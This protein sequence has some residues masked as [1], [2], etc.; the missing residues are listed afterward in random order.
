[1][2]TAHQL[3]TNNAASTLNGTLSVGATFFNVA[4]GHGTR[5]PTPGAGEYFHV[6][7][8]EI[9]SSG[10]EI[11]YEI[12]RC[13]AISGDTL[14]VQ[15]DVEGVV[16]AAGGTSGGWA[17]PSA[18]GINPSQ[19][20][21][22]ELRHTA[23]AAGNALAKDGNLAGLDSVATARTN[24][25][26]GSLATQAANAVAISGGTIAG[27]T[28]DNATIN[29]VD[30]LSTFADN[31]DATKKARFELGGITAG[32]TR[33]LTVPDTNGTLATT[34]AAQ[35]LTNKTLALGSNTVSGTKA[36][37]DAALTDDNFAFVGQA[38][39]FTQGQIVNL[40]ASTAEA[41]FALDV[42]QSGSTSNAGR[43][44]FS[45][46]STYGL[47]VSI[48][49]S[50]S[51]AAFA[52]LQWVQRSNGALQSTPLRLRYNGSIE[53]P[54]AGARILGDFSTSTVANRAAFK[55]TTTNGDTTITAL[56][57]GTGTKA[58]YEGRTTSVLGNS[59]TYGGFFITPAEM[60]LYSEMY[61]ATTYAP[62]T[63]YT[64]GLERMRIDTSGNV[65]VGTTAIIG[66]F[67]VGGGRALFGANSELFAI[68][69]GFTQN[70]V[71][72]G[73]V[74]YIGATD[75]ATPD[76]VFSNAAGFERFRITNSGD[77]LLTQA[78]GGL[79]YGTGAGGTVTQATSKTTAVTLNKP[80]GQITMHNA[81]LAAGATATF[82]LNNSVLTTNADDVKCKAVSGFAA[83][84]SYI[85]WSEGGGAGNVQIS[86]KNN[87]G[88]SLSE[89]IVIQFDVIKGAT[90]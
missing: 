55:T 28:I 5:F 41:E 37:F 66:R 8:F 76:L 26:L 81:A 13:T 23:Y 4:V 29:A 74:Y 21:Y 3:F 38:N 69:L 15:R 2:T 39:T 72:S 40:A 90:A 89:A 77:A 61:G 68:G 11:N 85:V 24:L 87:T 84:G 82:V 63:F 30:S 45:Q 17:Y 62:M 33:V 78:G 52:D 9:D 48:N 60:R 65:G 46:G 14:T 58:A 1:M 31:A 54:A 59:H 83:Q 71:Q 75:S 86:V 70:R 10:N 19:L 73:H 22:V 25:G 7:L 20:V 34:D 12:M 18:P 57:D 53:L 6:T 80:T 51:S 32:Q 50:A 35:A 56:P 43:A 47:G 67:N 64:G 16:V 79:G 27:V 42:R 88:G 49:S 36:Q 44:I